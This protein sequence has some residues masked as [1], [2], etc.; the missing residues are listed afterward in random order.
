MEG[1]IP[2]IGS[3]GSYE[4]SAPFTDLVDRGVS[5]TC[6]SLRT[7]SEL[8][9]K[10][11]DVWAEYYEPYQVEPDRYAQ[12]VASNVTIVGLQSGVGDWV[13]IP[14]TFITRI[15]VSN[16]IIYTTLVLGISLGAVPDN[17]AIGPL[18]TALA[19]VVKTNI[20]IDPQ[21]K[22]VVTGQPTMIPTDQ[23]DRLTLARQAVITS[24]E[25]D[26]ARAQ[27]LETEVE[28]LQTQIKILSDALKSRL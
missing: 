16:G 22:A 14:S 8:A 4:A 26:Y 25:T 19:N 21:M 2:N 20:G 28:R 7:I 9:S 24:T 18:S 27:R 5:Y 10:G 1:L 6:R 11:K 15:P 3:S 23:H 13:D 17:F 12:D